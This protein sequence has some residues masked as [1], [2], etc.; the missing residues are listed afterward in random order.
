MA[1]RQ[2]HAVDHP[3]G[4]HDLGLTRLLDQTDATDAPG[5]GISLDDIDAW[6]GDINRAEEGRGG[7]GEISVERGDNGGPPIRPHSGVRNTS[8]NTPTLERDITRDH[9]C[10]R[11]SS[12]KGETS[13]DPA[14]KTSSAASKATIDDGH[15]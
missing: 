6:P 10:V 11:D 1:E 2:V 9:A 8:G 12:C 15:P 13:N 14:T 5:N 7:T 3:Y 4:V